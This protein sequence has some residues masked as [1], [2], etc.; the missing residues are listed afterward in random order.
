MAPRG[1][2]EKLHDILREAVQVQEG[3]SAEPWDFQSVKKAGEKTLV[4]TAVKRSGRK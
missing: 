1:V 4:I 2:F 3:S